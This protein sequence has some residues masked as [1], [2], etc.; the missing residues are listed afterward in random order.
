MGVA[1]GEPRAIERCT[2]PMD[3]PVPRPRPATVHFGAAAGMVHP[4]T[5]YLVPRVLRTGPALADALVVGLSRSGPAE[6]ARLAFGAIWPADALRRNRLYR[7]GASAVA[8]FGAGD[9]RA[10]FRAFFGMPAA[11]R[12]GYLGDRLSTA[13]LVAGMAD[14]FRRLPLRVRLRLLASG[15]PTELVRA[16]TTSNPTAEAP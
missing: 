8:R 14:L 1:V 16:I 7:Y 12:I 2:I 4:A 6:A 13:T 15:D 11:F 3:A 5:G 9:T 10:F